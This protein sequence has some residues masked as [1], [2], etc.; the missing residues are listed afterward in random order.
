MSCYEAQ[1]WRAGEYKL[2]PPQQL[3]SAVALILILA[4]CMCR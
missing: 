4:W 1:M 2:P 3:A